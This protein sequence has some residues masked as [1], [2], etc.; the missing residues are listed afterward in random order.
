MKTFDPCGVPFVTVHLFTYNEEWIL[1]NTIAFYKRRLP[2]LE[3]VVHDNMSTDST[4]QIA[5]QSG[6]TVVRYDTEGIFD[7]QIHQRKKNSEW[8]HEP[9]GWKIVADADECL[10][11]T[12]G[13]LEYFDKN[14]IALCEGECWHIVQDKVGERPEDCRNGIRAPS[15]YDKTL[16]FNSLH[17]SEIN[18]APGA[19]TCSPVGRNAPIVRTHEKRRILHYHYAMSE[20]MYIARVMYTRQRKSKSDIEH[21][22]G[23]QIWRPEQQIR[24]EYRRAREGSRPII[25]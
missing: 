17:V 6:C 3:I 21:G 16:L 10:E 7:D 5:K 20:D 19:H 18:Y 25:P 9:M 1:P 22:Y 11:V 24:E 8:K 12:A 15:I 14:G 23:V 2:Y 13:D 4:V